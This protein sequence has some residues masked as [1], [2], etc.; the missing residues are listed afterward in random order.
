MNFVNFRRLV[1]E[2]S[3]DG[4]AGDKPTEGPMFKPT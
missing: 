1:R 4:Y 2:C 3:L